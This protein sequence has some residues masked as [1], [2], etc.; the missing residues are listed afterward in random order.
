MHLLFPLWALVAW[1]LTAVLASQLL[2]ATFDV[3]AC[4]S[5]CVWAI[6]WAA[7]VIT[8]T[9]CAAGVWRLV[10]ADKAKSVLAGTGAMF[11]LLAIFITTMVI[12]EFT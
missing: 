5:D 6:Y 9:G 4:Q 2:G 8:I 10:N 3:R 11:I 7:F 12:G 1:G